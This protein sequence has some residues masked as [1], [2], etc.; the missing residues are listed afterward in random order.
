MNNSQIIIVSGLP[1][2]G[3]SLMMQIL[4]SGGIPILC[5]NEV[6]P[7]ESN[8]RGYF[9]YSP[10][11]NSFKDISWIP[12]AHGKAVKVITQ[13]IPC[14]KTDVKIKI[15]FMERELK[16]VIQSQHKMILQKNNKTS[17][18]NLFD[19]KLIDTYTAQ[20]S[21]VEDW[22]QEKSQIEYIKIKYNQLINNPK[23]SIEQI[24]TFLSI[25]LNMNKIIEVIDPN[26]YRN[27]LI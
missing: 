22:I 7:D 15:I 1:R 16:E 4:H 21:K 5:D 2:S 10:V 18:S 11:K 26:L 6:L 12:Q 14:I 25:E 23:Y 3:T 24:N 20:I 9:E 8:P 27:K 13:L 19:Q 17:Q